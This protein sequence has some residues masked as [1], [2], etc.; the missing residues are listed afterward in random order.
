MP[1][2]GCEARVMQRP[3]VAKYDRAGKRL[4]LR[5]ADALT[6]SSSDTAAGTP[7]SVGYVAHTE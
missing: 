2:R 7:S 5:K 3:L 1:T 4:R 6:T